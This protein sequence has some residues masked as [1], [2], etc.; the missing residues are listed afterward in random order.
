MTPTNRIL[1][2][3]PDYLR[4]A[5]SCYP[6]HRDGLRAIAD[7]YERLRKELRD[8]ARMYVEVT[9]SLIDL[10]CGADK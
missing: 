3:A 10:Q 1:K 5:A 2:R 9:E 6:A 8:T 7:E 4:E